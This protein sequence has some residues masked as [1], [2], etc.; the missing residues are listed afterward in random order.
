MIDQAE[1]LRLMVRNTKKTAHVLAVTSGKGGVGKTNVAAN[2]AVCL[3]ASGKNVILMDADLGLAN[4]DVLFNVRARY[5]IAHLID[6][7]RRI[8]EI[9]QYGPAGVAMICGVSG[10][11]EMTELSSFQRRRIIQ[12]LTDI[13]HQADFIIIDTAA[14][15]SAN[16]LCFCEAARQTLV[17]TTPEPTSI[18]D[19]YAMIKKLAQ[20]RS[21]TRISLLVNMAESRAEAKN[22]YERLAQTAKKFLST[23]VYDAGYILRDEHV[24]QAVKQ[25]EPLVLAYPRCQA[26]YCFL[27]LTTKISRGSQA[28]PGESGFFH[29][30]V[31]WFF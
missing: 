24:T 20:T 6:G 1:K 30:V 9:I 23:V 10:I 28:S 27:A 2:L 3:T 29:K 11:T 14:G 16:V 13:E 4:I 26:S 7:R 19:A 12:Q 8:D 22:V 17:V 21:G 5:T 18:T 31:N 15:I 25:A